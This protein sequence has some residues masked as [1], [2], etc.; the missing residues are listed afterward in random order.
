M[1]YKEALPYLRTCQRLSFCP[2]GITPWLS[3]TYCHLDDIRGEMG[4]YRFEL[5]KQPND[6][7][8]L[9]NLAAC[10]IDLGKKHQALELLQKAQ[11]LAG[12]R[13]GLGYIR[14]NIKKAQE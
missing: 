13:P 1:C 8:A 7:Q 10:Y 3:K 4:V 12:R 9:N 14:R 11:A 2:E 6:A 5:R